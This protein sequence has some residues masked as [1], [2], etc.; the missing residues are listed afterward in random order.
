QSIEELSKILDPVFLT[1]VPEYQARLYWAMTPPARRLKADQSRKPGAM[2][3]A[4]MA[5][6]DR[7]DRMM[8]MLFR[9][10]REMSRNQFFEI[11]GEDR[12]R[13][14]RDFLEDVVKTRAARR[15]ALINLQDYDV[16]FARWLFPYLAQ[17][18]DGHDYFYLAALN[19]AC[20]ID[21]ERRAKILEDFDKHF[22]ELNDKV[23]DLIWELRPPGTVARLEKHLNDP[24]LKPE[25]RGR[26]VDVIASSEDPAAGKVLL[27][28]VTTDLPAE[29]KERALE[30]LKQL[31]PRKWNSLAKSDE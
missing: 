19:I 31:L 15:E 6:A 18:Y 9:L 10:D 26:M 13:L 11:L 5:Y 23:L 7:K 29:V 8:P 30:Q 27:K 3:Y 25:Q 21:P 14:I 12:K 16:D 4:M 24:G 22:P 28:L 20:G 17:E 2:G 1:K